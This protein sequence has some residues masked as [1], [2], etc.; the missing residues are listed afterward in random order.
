VPAVRGP[1]LASFASDPLKAKLAMS[2]GGEY[3][4]RDISWTNWR[5]F[6][7]SMRLSADEIIG[8]ARSMAAALPDALAEEMAN[9]RAGGLDHRFLARLANALI[10]RAR[11]LEGVSTQAP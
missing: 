10:D 11:R 1:R 3:R 7:A 5:Q 6:A 2:I 9:A 8:R 4:L